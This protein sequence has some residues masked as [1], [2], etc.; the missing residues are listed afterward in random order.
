MSKKNAYELEDAFFDVELSPIYAATDREEDGQFIMFDRSV[1]IPGFKAVKRVSDGMIYAVVKDSYELITNREAVELGKKCFEQ[2]FGEDPTDMM[3]FFN[4]RMP[5]S[6]SYCTIDFL[7]KQERVYLGNKK[8]EEWRLFLRISNSYNRKTAL[9][10]DI[11]FCRWICR[12]G[13]IF[14]KNSIEFKYCHNRNSASIEADFNLKYGAISAIKEIFRKK[15]EQLN[16]KEVK[17]SDFMPEISRALQFRAPKN[18]KEEAEEKERD[19]HLENLIDSYIAENGE[20]AYALLNVLTHYASRPAHCLSAL[21]NDPDTLER[22]VGEW[23]LK[24]VS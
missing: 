12:N 3:E 18:E 14:G 10:F 6:K 21:E 8:N 23:M 16:Q 11:G 5:Y 15:I 13:M 22:R 2:V 9:K 24:Q 7:A 17:R 19:A 20:T 4:L 1:K